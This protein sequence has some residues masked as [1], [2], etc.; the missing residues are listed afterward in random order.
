MGNMVQSYIMG[1][2]GFISS[3]VLKSFL[4]PKTLLFKALGAILML[5]LGSIGV[6]V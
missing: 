1:S 5:R 3:T 6:S 2:A 4:G